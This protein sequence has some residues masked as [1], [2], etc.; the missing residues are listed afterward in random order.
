MD[1]PIKSL[2]LATADL[3]GS[4]KTLAIIRAGHL[5]SK[6]RNR[7]QT[8]FHD[9]TGSHIQSTFLVTDLLN[10]ASYVVSRFGSHTQLLIRL[11]ED[12]IVA[13]V[14]SQTDF[15]EVAERLA[16]ELSSLEGEEAIH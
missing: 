3:D 15:V 1:Q 16:R 7:P 13:E 9:D 12:L 5:I 10:D 14:D 8:A 2:H 11:K 6:I 4:I